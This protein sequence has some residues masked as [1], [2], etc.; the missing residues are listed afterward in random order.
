MSFV[1]L[2]KPLHV[3]T[4]CAVAAAPWLG[5]S[6]GMRWCFIQRPK[7]QA[8]VNGSGQK[9]YEDRMRAIIPSLLLCQLVNLTATVLQSAKEECYSPSVYSPSRC[10]PLTVLSTECGGGAGST[11]GRISAQGGDTQVVSV[12]YCS[13]D[14]RDQTTCSQ[15]SVSKEIY[16]KSLPGLKRPL[17]DL[18]LEMYLCSIL[19][20][21]LNCTRKDNISLR[22]SSRFK[23][24]IVTWGR[25]GTHTVKWSCNQH[26]CKLCVA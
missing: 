25:P 4:D 2:F 1:S 26:L 9:N 22:S 24:C 17:T 8:E 16:L 3:Q 11:P 20:F 15:C 5:G 14:V 23:I 12:L 21:D 18:K 13:D 7:W 19:L 6:Y 10:L